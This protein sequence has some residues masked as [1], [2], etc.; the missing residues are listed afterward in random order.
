MLGKAFEEKKGS[1]AKKS[2]WRALAL[3]AETPW[4]KKDWCVGQGVLAIGF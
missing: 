2:N 3:R 1:K 4:A